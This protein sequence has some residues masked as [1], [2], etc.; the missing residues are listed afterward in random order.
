M[1]YNI[2]VAINSPH[3]Q[4][5]NI[6]I[7]SKFNSSL[8]PQVPKDEIAK[9]VAVLLRRTNGKDTIYRI[10]NQLVTEAGSYLVQLSQVFDEIN[11]VYR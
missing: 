4:Y 6:R 5:T 11:S 10:V 8:T 2:V 3:V 7:K 1:R 9:I